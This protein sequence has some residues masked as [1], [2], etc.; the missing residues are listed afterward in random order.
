[1]E[2][3]KRVEIV[4]DSLDVPDLLAGLGRIG[5]H[6][7]AVVNGVVGHGEGGDSGAAPF[8]GAFENTYVLIACSEAQAQQILA[9]VRPVLKGRGGLC[10]LS[11]AQRLT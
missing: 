7:Y 5:I 2:P 9:V 1:M 6:H 10:L 4:I 8:S 3:V 11:D